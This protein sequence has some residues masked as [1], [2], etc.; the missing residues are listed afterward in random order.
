MAPRKGL[1][2][3]RGGRNAP[4]ATPTKRAAAGSPTSKS[5]ASAASPAGVVAS[6]EISP[7][8]KKLPKPYA[9]DDVVKDSHLLACWRAAQK[10]VTSM[11]NDWDLALTTWN[12]IEM[13]FETDKERAGPGWDPSTVNCARLPKYFMGQ[14]LVG[15]DTSAVTRRFSQEVLDKVDARDAQGIRRIF[16]LHT[17]GGGWMH[18]PRACRED[19][20]LTLEVFQERINFVN[21]IR[22]WCKNHIEATTGSVDWLK[23]GPYSFVWGSDGK[24]TEVKFWLG[25]TAPVTVAVTRDFSFHD[26]WD[27]WQAE[28]KAPRG[29][30]RYKLAEFFTSDPPEGP[31]K[32]ATDRKGLQMSAFAAPIVDKRKAREDE[33]V[34]HKYNEDTTFVGQASAEKKKEALAKASAKAAL[35]AKRRRVLPLSGQHI[36]AAEPQPIAAGE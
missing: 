25:D 6:V 26:A 20:G 2:L 22:D 8:A 9:T 29:P 7:F 18:V 1:K 16:Y 3:Q 5:A 13:R 34:R 4:A 11:Q 36:P 27:P 32:F 21:G 31:H 10:V 14:C 15:A 23:A 19:K 33:V 35:G 30:G 28:V 24:A 17:M 12:N